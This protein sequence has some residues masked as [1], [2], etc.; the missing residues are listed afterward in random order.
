KPKVRG[1]GWDVAG[2]VESVG[3][4]VSDFRPGD[5]VMGIAEQGSFAE[6][7]ITS[8]N[9]LIAKP[10]NLSFEQAAAIP[11]SGTTALRAVRD[12]GKVLP[13]QTVM[14]VGAAGGVGSLAV[15]IARA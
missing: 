3:A 8:P 11:I 10:A 5:E 4:G 13:K 2:T 1:L 9:K 15:Q 6:F 14:V 12:E 7:V